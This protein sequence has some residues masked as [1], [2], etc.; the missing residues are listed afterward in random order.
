MIICCQ[1]LMVYI[2]NDSLQIVSGRSGD[3]NVLSA[4]I[5]VSLCL[6]L[7]GIEACTLQNYVNADLSPGSSA[8]LAI[9]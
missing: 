7:G 5:D 2:V 6:C 9:A 1:S 8:A 4:G 3:D